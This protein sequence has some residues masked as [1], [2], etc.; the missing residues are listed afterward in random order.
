VKDAL[1][2]A[3]YAHAQVKVRAKVDLSARAAD[4]V[5]EVKAGRLTRIGEIKVIGLKRIPESKV[6]AALGLRRGKRYSSDDLRDA[7][8]A[9][10][11]LRIFGR[12]D[13]S[14]DLSHPELEDVPILVTVQEDKLRALTLGGGTQLDSLKWDVHLR[15]DWEHKNWLGGARRFSVAAQ[16]G[17]YFFPTRLETFDTLFRLTNA[18]PVGQ[19]TTQL[20]QPSIFG[21]RTKGSAQVQLSFRPVL[22]A[23]DPKAD[24]REEVVLGYAKPS[25]RLG[26]ERSFFRQRV[27]LTPNYNLEARIP[28]S[29]QNDVP[30]GLETVLVSYPKLVARFQSKP[31]DIFDDRNKRDLVVYFST[32]LELAGLSINGTRYFGGSLSDLKIEPEARV[33]LP[34]LGKRWQD[35]QKVGN[36][37]LALRAK[38][39]FILAPDY[40]TTLRGGPATTQTEITGDAALR[41]QQKL[42]SRA[43]YSG[44]S[45]SNRGYSFSSISPHGPVG[46]LIPTRVNCFATPDNPSCTRPLGGFTLWE[47]SAE[48]RFAGFYPLTIVAF[49]DT[50]DVT[51]EIGVL[52]FKYPHLSV[53]PGLRYESPVGPL[54]LDLGIRVPGAQA[55]GQSGLPDEPNYP[56]GK[57]QPTLGPIP[58]A[59]WLAFGDAF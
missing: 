49:A 36:L 26:L 16:G 46:F 50:S 48:L 37:T 35:E 3:G 5:T 51:R 25:G 15:S 38:V 33:V 11:E 9:L 21:G 23:L 20:E 24:P 4:V 27:H 56:H 54:R 57:E 6:R 19:L 44:G 18:F 1:T 53:G 34:I 31:G 22:Y 55:I 30:T 32:S 28:F 42:L 14:P 52:G 40:G 7:A 41:D 59:I 10:N 58:G 29:Y 43:F 47:A 8:D 45:T 12:V 2:K 17:V 39:G 13:V